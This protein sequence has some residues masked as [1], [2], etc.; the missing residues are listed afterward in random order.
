MFLA[1]I[2]IGSHLPRA[3][4]LV[5]AIERVKYAISWKCVRWRPQS[6]LISLSLSYGIEVERRAIR[7]GAV[8]AW[9]DEPYVLV[10][11]ELGGPRT[12]ATSNVFRASSSPDPLYGIWK[13]TSPDGLHDQRTWV[14]SG[15]WSVLISKFRTTVIVQI[16]L[17][18]TWERVKILL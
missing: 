15:A 16:S 12:R 7:L 4:R 11:Q 8:L 10:G 5:G 18:N 9:S 13:L 3:A 2:R 14:R 17:D 1:V 6:Q